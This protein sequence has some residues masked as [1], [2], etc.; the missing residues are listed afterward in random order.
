MRTAAFEIARLGGHIK[1]N[2]SPGWMIIRR[3]FQILLTI[4]RGWVLAQGP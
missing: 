2:G 1:N 4:Q 3:G